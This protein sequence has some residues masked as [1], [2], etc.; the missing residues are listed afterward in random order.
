MHKPENEMQGV[1]RFVQFEWGMLKSA[2]DDLPEDVREDRRCTGT[3]H[4]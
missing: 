3:G 2:W 1:V 4:G